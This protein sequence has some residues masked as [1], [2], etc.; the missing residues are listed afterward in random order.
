MTARFRFPNISK[1]RTLSALV[2]VVG[3]QACDGEYGAPGADAGAPVMG[4]AFESVSCEFDSPPPGL[5]VTCGRVKV[6][7]RRDDPVTG[8]IAIKVAVVRAK[9]VPAPTRTAIYLDGGA[10][11]SSIANLT[12]HGAWTPSRAL[13][14]LLLGRVLVAIDRRG[15]GGSLPRLDCPGVDVVPLP[16]RPAESGLFSVEAV[17]QCR[18]RLV[19]EG[20]APP[21]YGTEAAA[22]DVEAVRQA[23]NLGSYDLVGSAHGAR[24]ALE[25][26]RRYPQRLRAVVLDSLTPPDVDALAEE[27]PSLERALGKAFAECAATP[28]CQTRFPDPAAALAEVVARLQAD[29]VEASSHGGSVTL[30]G[31]T[32]VQAVAAL[33]RDGHPSADLIKR[34]D[35][36]R[37]GDYS[38][39][40]AVLTSP[41]TPG[42]VGAFLSVACAEQMAATSIE[43]IEMTAMA[44][45]PPVRGALT[46]RFVALACPPWAV[47]AA[48]ERLRTPVTS[49]L[50]VLL[51]AGDRDPITPPA[52]ARK[53]AAT[54]SGAHVL[55]LAQQGHQ[56]LHQPCGAAAAATFLDNPTTAPSAADCGTAAP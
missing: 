38:F 37:A 18:S 35:D 39:I 4:A 40:A 5:E 45:S 52:F 15:T 30:D 41:R 49:A 12:Y 32:F 25:V 28:D 11:G 54:L 19:G 10:G 1:I 43:T 14:A 36:S 7:E 26:M 21:A 2:L 8:S 17:G 3:A 48:P 34:I 44:L 27:G 55:E 50:P 6:P 47:P 53:A 31:R 33:L 46:G 23:L 24:V 22:D 20:V 56:P 51:L 13:R 16:E 9:D 29:P 42:A